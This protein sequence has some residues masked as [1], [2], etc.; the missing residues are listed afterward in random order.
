MGVKFPQHYL[1]V[2]ECQP[3]PKAAHNWMKD[4]NLHKSPPWRVILAPERADV[5]R[6]TG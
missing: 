5:R 2:A 1:C 3:R 4:F 6:E